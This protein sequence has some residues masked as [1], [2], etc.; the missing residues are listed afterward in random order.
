MKTQRF[1]L[2]LAILVLGFPAAATAGARLMRT[3]DA[4]LRELYSLPKT[5]EIARSRTALILVDLQAEFFSGKLRL[6]GAPKA[7]ERA[8]ELLDWARAKGIVV[9]HVLNVAKDPDSAVFAPGSAGANEIVRLL[10]KDGERVLVKSAGGGF[11]NTDL[12][13]WLRA[14]NIETVLVAG[15]MTHLAVHLTACD[16]TVRGYRV[17]VAADATATRALPSPVGGTRVDHQVLQRA[18]LAAIGDRCGEVMSTRHIVSLR[19]IP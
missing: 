1:W 17:V 7:A 10:P 8:T 4:T 16:A 11:T 2:S 6:P 13:E 15:L 14:R 19:P 18:T 5:E 3:E 12:H 9:V